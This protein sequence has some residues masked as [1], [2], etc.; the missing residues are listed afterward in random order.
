M[1]YG[2]QMRF[3]FARCFSYTARN[4]GSFEHILSYFVLLINNSVVEEM[5]NKAKTIIKRAYGFHTVENCRFAL[6][7]FMGNLKLSDIEP[8]IHK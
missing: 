6:K 2:N 7:H 8:Q 4:M 3:F 5:N 1:A